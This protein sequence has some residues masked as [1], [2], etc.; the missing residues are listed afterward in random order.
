MEEEN[1]KL[2]KASIAD[3]QMQRAVLEAM[4]CSLKAEDAGCFLSYALRPTS[5]GKV[6]L[7]M[8]PVPHSFTVGKGLIISISAV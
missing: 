2:K 3:V 8:F 7:Y 4:S 6:V 5:Q 1:V